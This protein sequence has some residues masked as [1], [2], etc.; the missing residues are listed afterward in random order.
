MQPRL[1]AKAVR[2]G[3]LRRNLVHDV[4]SYLGR[5]VL[6]LALSGTVFACGDDDDSP[7]DNDAGEAGTGGSRAGTG[8]SRAGTGGGGAGTGGSSV[9]DGGV[10]VDECIDDSVQT[11][12][13]ECLACVCAAGAEE[14]IDCSAACWALVECVAR[15]CA[16]D[17]RDAACIIANCEDYLGGNVLAEAAAFYDVIGMCTDECTALP[18]DGG[19]DDTDGGS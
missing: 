11:A 14:T 18:S 16:G 13:P 4:A 17:G 15:D 6:V 3:F 19:T 8:G 12:G 5:G 7:G 10:S 9:T 2:R 1:R